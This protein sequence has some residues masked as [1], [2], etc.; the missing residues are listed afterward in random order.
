MSP[1]MSRTQ[2]LKGKRNTL[3]LLRLEPVHYLGVLGHRYQ[4]G[5]LKHY[6][7]YRLRHHRE[8]EDLAS[9]PQGVHRRQLPGQ[10]PP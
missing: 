9:F 10:D 6:P 1:P 3:R 4:I 5:R 8:D 2:H 7:K